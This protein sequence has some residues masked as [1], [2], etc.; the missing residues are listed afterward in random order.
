[1]FYLAPGLHSTQPH[2]PSPTELRGQ[3][4]FPGIQMHSHNYRTPEVFA[5]KVR[6]ARRL[7]GSLG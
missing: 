5:Q 4:L 2:L 3:D 1:M 7:P 6:G